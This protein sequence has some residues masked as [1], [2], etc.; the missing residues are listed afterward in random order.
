MRIAV[1]IT[2]LTDTLFP[3]AGRAT[4][5]VLERLGHEPVFPEDQTCCGQP[6][7]NAGSLDDARPL[8]EKFLRVFGGHRYVV[9]PS[10]S[11]TSMVRNHYGPLLGERAAE[12]HGKVFELCEFL[13]DV[14]QARPRGRFAARV[15]LHQSC[16]GLRELRLGN[17][18]ERI[19]PPRD[20]VRELLS[21]IEGLELVP[22]QRPDECCGFGGAFSVDE[23]A[24]SCRMGRDRIAD[25]E[26]AGAEIITAGDMSCLM[27]L[28]G[29]IRRD[30]KPLRVLHL[31][32]LLAQAEARA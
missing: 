5:R 24:V 7:A 18:T 25:H 13:H 9:C 30:K 21:G 6:M 32:E 11:C 27:H 3:Q 29:L 28:Q 19:L 31:A 17:G 10:G 20:K 16:H 1:F 14:V 15:G 2:C 23:E 12:L 22:L 4:V 8:A 26:H